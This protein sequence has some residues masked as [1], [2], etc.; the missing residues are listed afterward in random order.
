MLRITDETDKILNE[1]KHEMS[2]DNE[3]TTALRK[4]CRSLVG[5]SYQPIPEKGMESVPRAFV[6]PSGGT[7]ARTIQVKTISS[8]K[9][10][11]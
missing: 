3:E 9:E 6:P 5:D 10:K 1:R 2:Q 8:D 4:N 11:K 7:G